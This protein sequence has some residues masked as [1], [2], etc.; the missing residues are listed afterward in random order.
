MVAGVIIPVA[1]SLTQPADRIGHFPL[2]KL[3]YGRQWSAVFCPVRHNIVRSQRLGGPGPTLSPPRI[4]RPLWSYPA[5]PGKLLYEMIPHRD[6]Q[7][8]NPVAD[9]RR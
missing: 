8:R 7:Y 2:Y 4:E 6:S 1:P 9:Q 5:Q 3:H